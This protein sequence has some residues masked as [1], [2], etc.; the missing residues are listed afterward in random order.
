MIELRHLFAIVGLTMIALISSMVL[1]QVVPVLDSFWLRAV[2]SPIVAYLAVVVLVV[3]VFDTSTR[4]GT[5]TLFTLALIALFVTVL[6]E[7]M[8][9][10]VGTGALSID[11]ASL[12]ALSLK[13]RWGWIAVVACGIAST[14]TGA[15]LL[16]SFI[17]SIVVGGGISA[18]LGDPDA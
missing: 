8:I 15:L 13:I 14:L 12:A 3:F 11:L 5:E 2:G 7:G 6:N 10:L 16:S 18:L 4:T 9:G 1:D 17:L